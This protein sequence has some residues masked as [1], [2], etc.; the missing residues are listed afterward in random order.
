MN[1]KAVADVDY[2]RKL[3]ANIPSGRA[4]EPDEV[5]T[6]ITFLL[7]AGADYMTGTTVTTDGALSLTVA[8][9]A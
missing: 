5:T 6:L 1:E 3:E 8:Q 7:S 9:G 4:A 2:R